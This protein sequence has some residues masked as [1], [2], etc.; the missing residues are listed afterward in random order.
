VKHFSKLLLIAAPALI[1]VM[2]GCS[3]SPHSV[4]AKSPPEKAAPEKPRAGESTA[5]VDVRL[6]K[7]QQESGGIATEAA[8]ETGLPSQ[9]V[10]NGQITPNE[11][12][13]WYVGAFVTGRVAELGVNLGD[14]VEEGQV[15]LRIHSHDVHEV[16]GAYLQA[17]EAVQQAQDRAAYAGR[18]RDRAKR[19]LA[20]QAISREQADQAE[21]EYRT[22]ETQVNSAKAGLEREKTHLADVL[23]VPIDASGMPADVETVPVRA[24]NSGV[25]IDRKATVGTVAAEGA[26]L[27]TISDLSSLWVIA[28]VNESDL[29]ALHVG[30]RASIQVR[31]WPNQEF[32]GRV[33]RLG[34]SLNPTTRTLQVRILAPN[35]RGLLK[36]EMFATVLI[37]GGAGRRAI[38]VP[39]D[40]IQDINGQKT[41]F[42]QTG[43]ELFRP[44]AISAGVILN[45][46]VEVAEGLK[47]GDR[48]V[49]KG[50]FGLKSVMLKSLLSED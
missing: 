26:P 12:R 37:D 30:Q 9:V 22:A 44:Q 21:T 27:L 49:V 19:L 48:V 35:P 5:G 38:T 16:R 7:E 23:E 34:E 17:R 2:T 25:V 36:P 14:E 46:R 15:L 1:A 28:N 24:P 4:A 20:L 8:V 29:P 42:V 40:A 13:T 33:A 45:D 6:S 39:N 31:A 3:A 41:V 11:D 50:S 32:A 43:A 47:P 10:A 18:V